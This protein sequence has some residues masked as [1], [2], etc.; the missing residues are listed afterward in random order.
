MLCRGIL[1]MLALASM[2]CAKT[3]TPRT[4]TSSVRLA[5]TP[6]PKRNTA[7]EARMHI[8]RA[9]SGGDTG[10]WH[11]IET[12]SQGTRDQAAGEIQVAVLRQDRRWQDQARP[13]LPE[14]V[15]LR[16]GRRS[17][18]R[19]LP[20]MA[21]GRWRQVPRSRGRYA[22]LLDADRADRRAEHGAARVQNARD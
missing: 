9:G 1:S 13:E 5:S 15:L 21:Q 20:A 10:D 11:G 17:A 14:A 2:S 22:Q 19:A 4:E 7:D 18:A 12:E 6:P 8:A 3:W 16:L